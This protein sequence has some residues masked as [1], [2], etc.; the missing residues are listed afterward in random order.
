MVRRA[1]TLGAFIWSLRFSNKQSLWSF[2][3]QVFDRKELQVIIYF[4]W[5]NIL[6]NLRLGSVEERC[7]FFL[8]RFDQILLSWVVPFCQL[9]ELS[10]GY[11]LRSTVFKER[12]AFFLINHR[13]FYWL[14]FFFPFLVFALFSLFLRFFKEYL[15]SLAIVFQRIQYW[16][17]ISVLFESRQFLNEINVIGVVD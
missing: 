8:H 11:F 2:D 17:N 1:Y 13:F 3:L 16:N 4:V 7:F 14:D 12:S 6:W 10:W 5:L 15:W 9:F